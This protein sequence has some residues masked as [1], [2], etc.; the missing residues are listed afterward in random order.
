ML[1]DDEIRER[2]A[3]AYGAQFTSC[4]RLLEHAQ[5]EMTKWSGRAVKRGADRIILAEIARGTKTFDG[6]LRLCRERFGEQAAMLNRSLFEAM[7]IAHWTSIRRRE[8]VGLFVRHAQFTSVLWFETLDALGWLEETDRA[9]RPTI[10]PTKRAEFVKLFGPYGAQPWAGRNVPKLIDE[11]EHLWDETGRAQLRAMH[12]VPHR[13]NNQMLHSTATAI[14]AAHVGATSTELRLTI[15]PS[16]LLVE[17]ELLAAYWIYGQVVGLM[18][19]V[20]RL[21]DRTTFEKLFDAGMEAFN[22]PP[23]DET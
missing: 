11:I 5:A 16:N 15:G 2:I 17:Q 6:L 22:A 10:G 1:S 21:K 4:E 13:H 9:A 7:V 19:D 8:A 14:S 12:D 23:A 18:I 3:Q 20:F